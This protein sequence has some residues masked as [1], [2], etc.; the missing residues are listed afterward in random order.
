MFFFYYNWFKQIL[1][2]IILH[3]RI[4]ISAKGVYRNKSRGG[5]RGFP[6]TKCTNITTKPKDKGHCYVHV[7]FET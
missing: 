3:D 6:P 1:E 2:R 4:C 7:S 5:E